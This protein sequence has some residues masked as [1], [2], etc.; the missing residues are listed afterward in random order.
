MYL[1]RSLVLFTA[2]LVAASCS[3]K[4]ET[5]SSGTNRLLPPLEAEVLEVSI[6]GEVVI[7]SVEVRAQ[8]EPC[9]MAITISDEARVLRESSRGEVTDGSV[10]DLKDGVVVQLWTEPW[11]G[12]TC[13]DGAS[14]HV[15]LVLGESTVH[16]RATARQITGPLVA[17]GPQ[18]SA[19]PRIRRVR[20]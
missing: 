1:R 17:P 8:E 14:A 20:Q 18:P 13:A 6:V 7:L 16:R 15:V 3:G 19:R 11:V 2:C 4:P 9:V 5:P 10:A 12:A